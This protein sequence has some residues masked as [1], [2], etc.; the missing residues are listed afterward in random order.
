MKMLTL[1]QKLFVQRTA[2]SLNPTQSA[3]E[4]Y[5]CSSGSAKVIASINLRKPAVALALKEKLE[6]SGFS[7]ETIVEKLKELITANRITEYKGVAKMTNLPN[8]PERRKTL[9][10]VLNLMGAY[11][12]SRAEV[13]SV[14]AEFKGKLKELN[15][16]QLQ[17]LL[18]KKSD[19]E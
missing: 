11:P 18:G 7:D 17:G 19:D 13:K 15:I 2:Q 8:Y 16:E 9:D 1:K 12:P 4:V 5:D 10:M 14:K 3:R 6:I